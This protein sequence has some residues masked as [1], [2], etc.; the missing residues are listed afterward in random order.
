MSPTSYRAAPPRDVV[1][2]LRYKAS[3]SLTTSPELLRISA[4]TMLARNKKTQLAVEVLQA[5]IASLRAEMSEQMAALVAEREVAR[6]TVDRLAGIEARVSGMGSEL[7]RQ[8]HELGTEIEELSKRA[9]DS[10][11]AEMMD[12]LKTTQVRLANEQAR[13]E[14]TFRQDLAALANKLLQRQRA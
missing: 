14:I 12:A 8:L 5:E 13:Y 7:S 9:E 6:S 10:G 11:V 4:I 3:A 2:A 1:E